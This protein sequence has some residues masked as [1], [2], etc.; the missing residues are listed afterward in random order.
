MRL[1]F[2]RTSF[3]AV[4]LCLVREQGEGERVS[5]KYVCINRNIVS[6]RDR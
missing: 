1:R 2:F 6:M 4:W 5:V 3:S